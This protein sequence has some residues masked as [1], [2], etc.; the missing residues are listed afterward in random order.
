MAPDRPALGGLALEEAQSVLH[1]LEIPAYHARQ[2]LA[3]VHR[4]GVVDFAKMTDLSLDHRR[5]LDKR[6]RVLATSI[7]HRQLSRDGTIKAVVAMDDGNCVETVLIR[8]GDRNTICVSTQVGCPVGCRFCASGLN[9]LV[10]SLSAAEIV[11]QFLQVRAIL[12][13]DEVIDNAVFMGM[14]EPL[15][16]AEATIAA[17]RIVNA[18]WGMG[19]GMNRITLSTVGILKGIDRLIAERVTPNLALSLHAATDPLRRSIVPGIKTTVE[20][21]LKA[22][23]DYRRTTGKDVTFEYVLLDGCNDRD[24]DA[25]ALAAKVRGTGCKVNLIVYNAV[26]ETPYR[27]SPESAVRRFTDILRRSGLRVTQRRRKGDDIDAACGQLRIRY[28]DDRA[29]E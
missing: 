28:Q 19:L 3:W 23:M 9:G 16:N 26:D 24:E 29:H 15:L 6:C 25:R 27:P 7:A 2:I 1:N 4:R 21:I 20:E 18:D 12:V 11:E 17:M 5:T 13:R 10:R 14:G 8:E 22:G